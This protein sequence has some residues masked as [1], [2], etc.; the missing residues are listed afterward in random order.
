[1]VFQTSNNNNN[2]VSKES[3]TTIARDQRANTIAT[4]GRLPNVR[5][6]AKLMV[7]SLAVSELQS[8]RARRSNVINVTLQNYNGSA[9]DEQESTSNSGEEHKQQSTTLKR[10]ASH[11]NTR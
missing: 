7:R 5:V 3:D 2:L 8:T 9:K 4:V 1:M 6:L 10:G 11:K